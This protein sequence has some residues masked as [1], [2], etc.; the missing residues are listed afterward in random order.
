MWPTKHCKHAAYD[1]NKKGQTIGWPCTTIQEF[2][3][4]VVR[5]GFSWSQLPL[6]SWTL[7]MN[8]RQP[9]GQQWNKYG[10]PPYKMKHQNHDFDYWYHWIG[11]SIEHYGEYCEGPQ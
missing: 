5:G 2:G 9:H 7:T 3:E 8:N 4:N 1:S 6:V 10:E 11:E